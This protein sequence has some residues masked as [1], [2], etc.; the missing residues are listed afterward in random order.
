MFLYPEDFDVIPYSIPNLDKVENTFMDYVDTE[1]EK[2]LR[3]ILGSKLYESFIQGIGVV[4]SNSG[5][6]PIEDKWLKLR[7]GSTYENC[8]KQYKYKGMVSLL[9]PYIYAM[10]LRD[11]WDNH[12]G[13]GIVKAD[14]ENATVINPGRRIV[15]GYNDFSNQVGGRFNHANTL[16]GFLS[17]NSEDYPDWVFTYQG[18]MNIFNL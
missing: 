6:A 17:V 12:S 8:G 16:Y 3:E 14:A 9:K 7:D 5:D 15:R 1:E 2:V 4:D 18:R 11:S 10:W 13:I